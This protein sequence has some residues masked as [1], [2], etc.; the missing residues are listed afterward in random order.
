MLTREEWTRGPGTPPVERAH[1]VYIWAQKEGG[2]W[3]SSLW[4]ICGKKAQNF[5]RKLCYSIAG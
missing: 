1:L 5:S 4:A 2:H 3:T